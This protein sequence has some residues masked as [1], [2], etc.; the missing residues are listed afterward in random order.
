MIK[1]NTELLRSRA[2]EI[3]KYAAEH[4]D[5][6]DRVNNLVNALPEIWEGKSEQDFV[7]TFKGLSGSFEQFD[8]AL[9]SYAVALE[10]AA[11]RMEAAD[12]AAKKKIL[13]IG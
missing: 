9:E 5:A 1:Y 2:A 4:A 7:S 3:R 13:A 11:N 10:D 6:I 8:E 12:K